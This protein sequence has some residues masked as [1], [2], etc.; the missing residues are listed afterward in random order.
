MVMAMAMA[1]AMAM[2]VTLLGLDDASASG[3]LF[4]SIEAIP[5]ARAWCKARGAA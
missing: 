2:T 3:F 4:A 1:M 5:A